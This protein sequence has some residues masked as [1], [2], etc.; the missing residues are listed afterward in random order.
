MAAGGGRCRDGWPP[1]VVAVGTGGRRGWSLQSGLVIALLALRDV[2]AVVVVSRR[3]Y[4]GPYV[5][6]NY[7]IR[8]VSTK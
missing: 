7:F 6:E 4:A 8:R 5:K 3:R 1:G 2:S